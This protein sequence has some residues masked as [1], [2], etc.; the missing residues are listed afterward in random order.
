[1]TYP[2]STSSTSSRRSRARTPHEEGAA[3][4]ADALVQIALLEPAL[5]LAAAAVAEGRLAAIRPL[6]RVLDRL[7]KY[8][9]VVEAAG[10]AAETQ[11][12]LMAKLN[13]AA[14][15]SSNA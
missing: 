5:R 6:I 1:M 11:E 2:S 7:D 3:R 4:I 10:L 14:A 13:R 15:P 8:G 12:P 9:P